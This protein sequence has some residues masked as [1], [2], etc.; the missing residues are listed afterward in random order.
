MDHLHAYETKAPERYVLGELT[1]AEAEDFELHYFD[2]EQCAV[3]VESS[4][5][6]IANA[7]A[8]LGNHE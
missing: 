2:C 1:A 3:A 4:Q 8:V 7:R 5:L 6:F